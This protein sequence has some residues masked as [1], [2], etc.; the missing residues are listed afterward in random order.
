MRTLTEIQEQALTF[1]GCAETVGN[2]MSFF[3]M[4]LLSNTSFMPVSLDLFLFV[5]K[6]DGK[7]ATE[8]TRTSMMVC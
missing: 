1:A 8:L 6:L 7:Y 3:K 4:K 5:N 2:R